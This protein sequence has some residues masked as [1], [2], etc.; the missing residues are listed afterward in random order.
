MR[1]QKR[2]IAARKY[3]QIVTNIKSIRRSLSAT[4]ITVP[5][6]VLCK[7]RANWIHG[8]VCVVL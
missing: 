8:G 4:I 2:Q 6:R 7:S 5:V 1:P 3:K